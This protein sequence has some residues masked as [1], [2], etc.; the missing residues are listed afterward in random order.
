MSAATSSAPPSPCW[1]S[2]RRVRRRLSARRHRDRP[3]GLPGQGRREPR[4]AGREG[5]RLEADRA[6]LQEA[7][8]RPPGK[9]AQDAD[10]NPVL[11]P[12]PRYFQSRPSVTGYNPSVTFFNN[13]GPNNKELSQLFRDNLEAYIALERPYNAGPAGPPTSPSTRSPRRPPASTPTSPRP[14]RASRRA[15]SPRVRQLPL[16]RVSNSSTSNTDDRDLRRARGARRERARAEPGRRQG[17][18]RPMT[19]APKDAC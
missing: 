15:G 11:E 19:T 14:T 16:A 5:G 12:D 18:S 6:G 10:G 17:G 3:G 1:S 8:A 13:L 7:R 9:A 2:H 4:R